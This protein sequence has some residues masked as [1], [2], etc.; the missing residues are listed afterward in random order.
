M[1]RTL[2]IIRDTVEGAQ[3]RHPA[4]SRPAPRPHI[5][6]GSHSNPERRPQQ[7]DQD[8]LVIVCEPLVLQ[9]RFAI[10]PGQRRRRVECGG[11][12]GG[13]DGLPHRAPRTSALPHARER[14]RAV[15]GHAQR[16]AGEC[17]GSG[18]R[19]KKG[20]HRPPPV[21]T[22][23][24]NMGS[25]RGRA[26]SVNHRPSRTTPRVG[27]ARGAVGQAALTQALAL[28]A[29]LVVSTAFSARVIWSWFGGTAVTAA[30]RALRSCWSWRARAAQIGVMGGVGR[31]S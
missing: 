21:K 22:L 28:S 31:H 11:A 9:Q 25:H 13:R 30:T 4:G 5:P 27:T 2:L 24:P 8:N 12:S 14:V 3:H 1:H 23:H 10:W 26:C 6:P 29:A 17:V 18:T 19:R 20:L 7:H 15:P 16:C